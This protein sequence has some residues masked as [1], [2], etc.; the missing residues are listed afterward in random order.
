ME[1][2]QAVH[3]DAGLGR[4]EAADEA[5]VGVAVV[6]EGRGE[7]AGR[8]AQ[9]LVDLLDAEIVEFLA[10]GHRHDLGDLLDRGRELGAGCRRLRDIALD[11]TRIGYR[12]RSVAPALQASSALSRAAGLRLHDDLI[13]GNDR[14]RHCRGRKHDRAGDDDRD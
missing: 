7:D 8:I 14:L 1:Q 2:R 5:P 6:A 4:L 9:G 3:E 10:A 12:C 11:R 13:E